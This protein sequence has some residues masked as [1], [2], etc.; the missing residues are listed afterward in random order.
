MF[1]SAISGLASP[2]T[3]QT[4]LIFC[5]DIRTW[6]EIRDVKQCKLHAL[7]TRSAAQAYITP[8]GAQPKS[9]F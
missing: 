8:E 2:A 1:P 9:I 4:V 5:V 6:Q 3:Q 7:I